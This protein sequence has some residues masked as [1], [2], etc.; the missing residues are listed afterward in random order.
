MD[1]ELEKLGIDEEGQEGKDGSY[2]VTIKNSDEWGKIFS[3][4]DNSDLEEMEENSLLTDNNSSLMFRS[5]NYQYNLSAD[6]SANEYKLVITDR[7]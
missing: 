5:D 6:F 7:R 2:V 4:L 1:K 3:K